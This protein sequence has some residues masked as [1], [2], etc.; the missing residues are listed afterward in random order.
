MIPLFLGLTLVNLLS[1]GVAAALGYMGTANPSHRGDHQLAGVLATLTCCGVHCVVFT[2][3]IATA[4]WAQHAVAVKKLEPSLLA[5]TRSFKAQAFPAA[6]LAIAAVF[7]TAVVGVATLSYGL[8]PVFHHG[9]AIAA[10]ATNAAVAVV[11]YRAIR[12]NGTLI[13]GILAQINA[14]HPA[15]P[16]A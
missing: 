13:D 14:P 11:E 9:M 4:K 7:A 3:F 16:H 1:L 10:F 2:Y 5:P 6:L 12:K 8:R 15:V